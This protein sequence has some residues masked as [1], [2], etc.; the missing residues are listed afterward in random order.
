MPDT[1][2][3]NPALNLNVTD[4]QDVVTCLDHAA[5]QGA[6][7]SWDTIRQ[8]LA[9]R[10]KLHAFVTAATAMTKGAAAEIVPPDAAA[11]VVEEPIAPVTETL[12]PS[13]ASR[14]SRSRTAHR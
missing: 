11:P 6:Y 10:D 14:H 1:Q 7:R 13:F 5:D 8:V 12:P 9:L 2:M 4:I 3:P